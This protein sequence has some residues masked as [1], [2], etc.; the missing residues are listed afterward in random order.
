MRSY[1]EIYESL[2]ETTNGRFT[3][4]EVI[5]IFKSEDGNWVGSPDQL[6][7]IASVSHE[8][9]GIRVGACSGCQISAVNN[10]CRWLD[11][12][13]QN[14]LNQI[15]LQKAVKPKVKA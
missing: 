2:K 1:L 9:T 3:T 12:H 15:T 10:L 6:R 8:L 7:Q 13:E 14:I 4:L 11:N 5:K